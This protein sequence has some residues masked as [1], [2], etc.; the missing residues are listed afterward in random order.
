M[1]VFVYILLGIT[2]LITALLFIKVKV[3]VIYENDVKVY[4]KFLF[5]KFN[6]FAI[7]LNNDFAFFGKAKELSCK[8]L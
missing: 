8:A 2:L 5:F 7:E 4:G 3:F 1:P 6:I